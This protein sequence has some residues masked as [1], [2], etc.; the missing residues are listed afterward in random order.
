MTMRLLHCAAAAALASAASFTATLPS[1]L[2]ATTPLNFPILDCVGSSH[3]S[4][5]LRA[6]YREHLTRV[7]RDIGF[8]H[9]RGHGLLNDDMSSL[10]DGHAN[11]ANLFS[12]LDFYQSVGIKPIL[13]LSFMPEALALNPAR[14]IMHYKGITSTFKSA[15][16]WTAFIAEVLQGLQARY[17]DDETRSWRFEVWNEPQGCG[18]FCPAPNVTQLDGYF[19]LYNATVAAFAAVD[20]LLSVGGPATAQL[21]WVAE[22]INATSAANPNRLHASFLSTHS[23][24][25]DYKGAAVTRTVWEDNI[26]AAAGAAEAAGLPLVMTEIS[27]GLGSQYDPP[28]AGAFVLHAAAAFLGVANVP[29]LSF[30]T[31]SDVFEEPG[32]RS[33]PY[34]NEFGIPTKYGVPK[35]SYRAF[36]MLARCPTAGVP[37]AADAGGAPRRPGA[38]PAAACTATAGTVDVITAIDASLGTTL[39][40]HA[41]VS[42]WNANVND[43]TNPATGLPIATAAGVVVRFA[44]LPAGAVL[45]PTATVTLLN[46]TAGWARPAWVAAGS[47]EYPSSDEIA[48]ELAASVPARIA[49]PLTAAAGAVMVTLPDLEPYAFA[50]LVIEVALPPA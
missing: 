31:F 37:V 50:A 24:P 10:L 41:L 26:I 46:S 33:T 13:E 7:Q 27:A 14:T 9:I 36:E 39:S 38:G 47:P 18:F 49:L 3:G 48:A 1:P 25:T 21:A 16:A 20:P 34:V 45:P 30:W 43:A 22:F 11:L 5:A 2:T 6:D 29:T 15:A 4:M 44:G 17:G 40:L 42:N 19:A 12:V 32:F 23:Y 8:K 28:F 35:P